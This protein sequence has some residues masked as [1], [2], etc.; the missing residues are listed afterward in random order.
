[1]LLHFRVLLGNP[2]PAVQFITYLSRKYSY[3]L[4]N[5]VMP[6]IVLAVM[7]P[8]VFMLPVESGEKI[9]YALTI[10]LSLSVVMTL[11]SDSIPP[12]STPVCILS[13]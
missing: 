1:M 8:F 6:V 10:L 11:V 5:M 7:E 2:L 3:Y 4:M 12:T 13:E 9:G